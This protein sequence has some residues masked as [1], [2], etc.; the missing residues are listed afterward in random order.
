MVWTARH[1]YVA[2]AAFALLWSI[3]AAAYSHLVLHGENFRVE[4]AAFILVIVRIPLLFWPSSPQA[5]IPRPLARTENRSLILLGVVLWAAI[6]LPFVGFPFLS[7][8][9]VF[10]ASF[11]T[12]ADA[13]T[14][15][16]FFRPV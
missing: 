15:G 1:R 11:K 7:D 6:M 3:D 12:W 10:L 4:T 2:V 14:V 9:Y 5:V 13:F 16:Q 8:D